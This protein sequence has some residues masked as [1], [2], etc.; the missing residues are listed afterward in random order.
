MVATARAR[1]SWE[2]VAG[3]VIAA[4]FGL[5]DW[6]SGVV[7]GVTLPHVLMRLPYRDD[8]SRIEERRVGEGEESR[9]D[10]F[11]DLQRQFP[12]R[13]DHQRHRNAECDR[14]RETAERRVGRRDAFLQ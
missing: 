10:V 9:A 4:P 6:I 8:G 13:R 3:G 12:C 14:H 11:V 7:I 5:A 2:G 1:F